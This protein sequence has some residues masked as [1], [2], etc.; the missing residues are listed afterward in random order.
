MSNLW[1]HHDYLVPVNSLPNRS[2]LLQACITVARSIAAAEN[3]EERLI[4]FHTL[5]LLA[6]ELALAFLCEH[7]ALAVNQAGRQT[8]ITGLIIFLYVYPT[9]L[10]R[11]HTLIDALVRRFSSMLQEVKVVTLTYHFDSNASMRLSRTEGE[12][13]RFVVYTAHLPCGC[14][15]GCK[16]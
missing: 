4:S 3:V 10:T 13:G 6:H 9:L 8:E 5:D 11:L 16:V 1:R 7:V 12:G 15:V 14:G 2:N